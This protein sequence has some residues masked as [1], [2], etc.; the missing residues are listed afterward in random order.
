[1]TLEDVARAVTAALTGDRRVRSTSCTPR[2]GHITITTEE[3][4]R[5]EITIRRLL[6]DEGSCGD[7]AAQ[8][9]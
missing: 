6:V 9:Q 7:D 3:D 5:Y 8:S 1:M 4:V 2:L